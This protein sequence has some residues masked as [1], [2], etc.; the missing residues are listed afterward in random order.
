MKRSESKSYMKFG[1]ARAKKRYRA[2]LAH[3]LDFISESF[4]EFE[5][6]DRAFTLQQIG[7]LYFS[8]KR[9][10]VA[11]FYYQAAL[12][13]DPNS[14]VNKLG[15]A[16]FFGKHLRDTNL[17]K[18]LCDEIIAAAKKAPPSFFK[19][20]MS[21]KHYIDCAEQLKAEVDRGEFY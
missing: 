2:A 10:G 19:D 7:L 18:K 13:C 8:M 6:M 17:C 21:S 3:L 16:T 15:Y 11:K 4:E 9:I 20:N 5:P 1:R 12:A 14:L